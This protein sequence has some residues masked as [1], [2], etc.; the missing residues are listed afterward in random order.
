[1][2]IPDELKHLY[3]DAL[4]SIHDAAEVTLQEEGKTLCDFVLARL[5]R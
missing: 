2:R 5:S 4:T 3:L 1:M